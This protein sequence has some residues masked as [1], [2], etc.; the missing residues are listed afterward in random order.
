MGC[1]RLDL[2]GY[3]LVAMAM[4]HSYHPSRP[5]TC[6]A[7]CHCKYTLACLLPVSRTKCEL[8]EDWVWGSTYTSVPSATAHLLLHLTP[9]QRQGQESSDK[10]AGVKRFAT[11]SSLLFCSD[12]PTGRLGAP[13]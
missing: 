8:Q 1:S 5:R 9:Q 4:S 2:G 6:S 12:P 10:E 3:L 13:P 11:L 7:P